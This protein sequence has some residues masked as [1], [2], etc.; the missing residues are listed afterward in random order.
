VDIENAARSAN[1]HDFIM[2]LPEQYNTMVR[3]PTLSP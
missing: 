3:L 2:S 1:I